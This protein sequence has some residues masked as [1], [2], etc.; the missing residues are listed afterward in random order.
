M[1][2]TRCNKMKKA[3]ISGVTGLDGSYLAENI[4]EKGYE[5]RGIK[6]RESDI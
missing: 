4:L 1:T 5:L 3:L 2:Q 6:R